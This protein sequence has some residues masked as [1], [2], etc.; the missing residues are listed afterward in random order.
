M[1]YPPS[2]QKKYY[3]LQKVLLYRE[4]QSFVTIT[5]EVITHSKSSI[6]LVA[7]HRLDCREMMTLKLSNH[8][9]ARVLGIFSEYFKAIQIGVNPAFHLK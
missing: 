5:L 8:L 6:L 7:D 3:S 2:D 9:I 1:D 4:T